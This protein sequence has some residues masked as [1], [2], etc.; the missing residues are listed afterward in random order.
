MQHFNMS[1]I[2]VKTLLMLI[3]LAVFITCVDPYFP[4]LS[5][6]ES[7]LVVDGLITD[8]NAAYLVR[9]SR[10]KQ[11]RDDSTVFV[12]D[13]T[14]YITDDEGR[15]SNLMLDAPG[16][17]KTDSASFTGE[18]GR[19]Y[20]L[21]FETSDGRIYESEPCLMFPVPGIDSIYY[22]K[23]EEP[24]N[25]WKEGIE[26][27]LIYLDSEHGDEN[28]YYRW[29]F[30]ETWKFKVPNPTKFIYINE[31]DIYE[32]PDVKEFCWRSHLSDDILIN[33]VPFGQSNRIRREPLTFIAPARS[34]RLEMLYSILVKQYSVSEK[35]YN[36]WDGLKM[37]N[38]SGGDIFESQPFAVPGNIHNINNPDEH[39]L[40]YFQVSSVK[41]KRL[42][43]SKGELGEMNLPA[44]NYPCELLY[45]SPEDYPYPFRTTFDEIYQLYCVFQNKYAFVGP[46]YYPGTFTLRKLVFTPR[47]CAN[48]ELTGNSKRPAF[49]KDMK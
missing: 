38:E 3:F 49:W 6:Y 25:E 30:E 24:G 26:G 41:E 17:Y 47:E 5:G 12:S 1:G 11:E 14:V 44:Y 9:I 43:I 46:L 33:S 31:T 42:Y 28:Q 2:R 48:C 40:G 23:H 29:D 7:L 20:T 39:I 32:T 13:A 19:S 36:F 22:E 45:R 4:H 8:E 21:H 16:T 27:I 10:T 37:V 18:A 15:Q 35:E 34:D